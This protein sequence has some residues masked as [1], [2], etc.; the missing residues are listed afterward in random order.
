M[1]ISTPVTGTRE[2]MVETVEVVKI[3]KA[4]ETTGTGT[5]EKMVETVEVVEIA[6][7]IETTGTGQDSG[8]SEGEYP[9]NLA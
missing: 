3:A 6:K 7:A 9:E 8:K 5:R 2:E 4:V 1:V